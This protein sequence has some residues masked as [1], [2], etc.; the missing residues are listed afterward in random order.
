MLGFS[1]DC[2][3]ARFHRVSELSMATPR[4]HNDPPV[5]MQQTEHVP[6]LHFPKLASAQPN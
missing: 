5:V 2:H 4:R 6:N 1:S 3:A